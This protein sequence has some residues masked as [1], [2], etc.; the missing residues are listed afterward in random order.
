MK[1]FFAILGGMGTLATT[2]FL[3][4]LNKRHQPTKDQDFF[5]YVLFNHAEVPD[6]TTYILDQ[7][8]PNPLPVLLEAI[9]KINILC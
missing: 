1:N 3:V 9:A 4:E 5:N 8:A 6:R 7:S 2:N